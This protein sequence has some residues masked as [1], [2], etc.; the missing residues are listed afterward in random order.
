VRARETALGIKEAS[1]NLKI[2]GCVSCT[3][4]ENDSAK[5]QSRTVSRARS[6]LSIIIG[7]CSAFSNSHISVSQSLISFCS[8]L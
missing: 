2:L 3:V 6:K 1:C 4:L 5:G 7:L 8:G